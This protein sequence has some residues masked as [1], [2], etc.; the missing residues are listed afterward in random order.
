MTAVVLDREAVGYRFL[1]QIVHH[2][3]R[4]RESGLIGTAAVSFGGR[5]GG[6][7]GRWEVI[8]ER[9]LSC[10]GFGGLRWDWRRL[11]EETMRSFLKRRDVRVNFHF[12]VVADGRES[13]AEVRVT[14]M[15][16]PRKVP[17]SRVFYQHKHVG[18]RHRRQLHRRFH[19]NV[20][21]LQLHIL[22]LIHETQDAARVGHFEEIFPGG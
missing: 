19:E 9:P 10:R 21:H 16:F 5:R 20:G 12:H 8:V 4:R 15:A 22:Q 1:L 3:R 6:V 7:G 14:Q 2:R 18:V 13:M 11:R 17:A